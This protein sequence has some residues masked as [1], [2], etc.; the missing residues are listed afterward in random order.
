[1]TLICQIESLRD[2]K[3]GISPEHLEFA[4]VHVCERVGNGQHK[5]IKKINMQVV[6]LGSCC[7]A[8]G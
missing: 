2:L 6:D 7:C 1:M 8:N 4:L 5:K 3:S